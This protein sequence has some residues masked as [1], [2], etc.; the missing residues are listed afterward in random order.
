MQFLP[1]IPDIRQRLSGNIMARKVKRR[2]QVEVTIEKVAFGGKGI[3]YLDDYVLFVENTLPGDRVKA[4]VRKAKKNYAEAFPLE[5]ITPSELRGDAPCEHFGHCGGCKWQSVSYDQQLAFK[6]AHVAES[7]A[8]IGGVEP[9]VLHDVL[10]AEEIFGY[11]NKMEFSFSASG[12]LTPEELKNPEIKKEFALGFHVPRFYDRILNVN[13]CHLQNEAMNAVL[14]FSRNYFAQSGM[15]VYNTHTKEGNLRYLV[16]REARTSGDILVNV[17]TRAESI[18]FLKTYAEQLQAACP[19][20][21][22]VVNTVNSGLAQI[23]TGEAV[24]LIDGKPLLEE[25]LGSYRFE[26]SPESF[27]QTNT[28]Q[29]ENLYNVVRDFIPDNVKVAWDLYCGTG[30]IGIYVSD[31]VQRV[32]GFELVEAAIVN[33]DKNA[34]LNDIENCQFVAGDLRFN[35]DAW[36][37]DPPDLIICDPPR[38]GMHK[39]VVA[40]M[41]AVN[42][43]NIIYVSCNPATMARDLEHLKTSYDIVEVQPVDMFPHTFHIESVARLVR[44]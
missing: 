19:Q 24:H 13:Y 29:A 25:K 27:F 2:Q 34:A 40:Q 28:R 9:D 20:V 17:V 10:P 39:D 33:A 6:K 23:A 18:A 22:G 26:I 43:P 42:P 8:H 11:R 7:L 44:R 21:S 35:L 15:S 4:K 38:A 16:L 41:L 32:V 37:D 5:I 1:G 30:S 12:W 14:T 31:K 3:A 36:S